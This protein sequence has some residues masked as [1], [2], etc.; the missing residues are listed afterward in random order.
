MQMECLNDIH[1]AK[2]LDHDP[3]VAFFREFS[4]PG[5]H[6]SAWDGDTKT[7]DCLLRV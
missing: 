5:G 6:E 1:V 3:G 7:K 2:I 4:C